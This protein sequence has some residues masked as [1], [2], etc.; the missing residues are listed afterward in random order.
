MN[1]AMTIAHIAPRS[2]L[3]LLPQRSECRPVE[4]PQRQVRRIE[5]GV[6]LAIFLAIV[7]A[8]LA[9]KIA[10]APDLS[11]EWFWSIYS[12]AV[13]YYLLSRFALAPGY[14]PNL[15]RRARGYRP[16]I[17]VIVPSMNEEDGI[18][19][20]LEH[21]VSSEYPTNLLQVIAID[22]GSTDHT[23][24]EMRRVAAEHDGRIEVIATP[25]RGKR[26]AMA[27]GMRRATGE[28]L[29]FV[30]SD[31]FIAPDALRR[32]VA[33][34]LDE[35]IGA[36]TGHTDVANASTNMLTKMQAVRYFVAFKAYKSAEARFG[37]VTC[38]AGCFSG[39]RASAVAPVVDAWLGQTFLGAPSTYGDDRSLTNFILGDW[40]VLYAPD[41]KATTVVPDQMAKFLRQ[42]L[43]W[44]KS[45]LR[46]T[47]RAASFMWRRHP[48][49][50][51][52]FYLGLLLPLLAPSVVVRSLVARPFLT[53]QLPIYYI[54][55]LLAIA[56]LNGLY[57]RMYRRDSLWFH[58]TIAVLFY[59]TLLVWQL[60]WAIATLRDSKWGTR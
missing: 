5:R 16:T 35:G 27:E 20:T 49:M 41:A 38:C 3:D 2:A 59:T 4:D 32:L 56:V 8:V 37:S 21:I 33:Y 7:V 9:F 10:L 22:D 54:G 53:S 52:S 23:L 42:Q 58:G 28:I 47:F 46:E 25:N 6:I 1:S 57:Y 50:A 34:F 40:R 26:H 39:Y 11:D 15:P 18:G 55:G 19:C 43:R 17:T 12:I 60:P 14:R 44:K 30:D 13:T 51:T 24:A 45:W 29:V 31:S 36:V 48:L